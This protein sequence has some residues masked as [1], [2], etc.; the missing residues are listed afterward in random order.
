MDAITATSYWGAFLLWRSIAIA[1]A[2]FLPYRIRV[3]EQP[4][5][6]TAGGA[7]AAY[8]RRMKRLIPFVF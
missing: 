5:L 4:P 7:Y 2:F 3:E 6:A 8:I 1:G